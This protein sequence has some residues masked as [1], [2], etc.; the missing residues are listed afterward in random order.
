[1]EPHNGGE[2]PPNQRHEGENIS[3]DASKVYNGLILD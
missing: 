2:L 3:L 1:M